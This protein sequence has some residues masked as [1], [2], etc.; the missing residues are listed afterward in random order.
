MWSKWSF[1]AL[2]DIAYH[3]QVL[4]LGGESRGYIAFF[5]LVGVFIIW[6]KHMFV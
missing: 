3:D 1:L 4:E 2:T 6:G 5:G